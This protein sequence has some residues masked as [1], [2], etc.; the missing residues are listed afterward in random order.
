MLHFCF[1]M[2]TIVWV[3]THLWLTATSLLAHDEVWTVHLWTV[4]SFSF[5]CLCSLGA[6]GEN[7]SVHIWYT[8]ITRIYAEKF[9]LLL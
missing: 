6:S 8:I 3:A 4:V 2:E 1:K 9:D 7:I 5:D